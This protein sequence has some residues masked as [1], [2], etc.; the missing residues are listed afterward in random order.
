MNCDVTLTADEFKQVHNALCELR[1]IRETLSGVIREPIT[2]KMGSAIDS[3][4][5]GLQGAYAQDDAAA[6]R[7]SEHYEKVAFTLGFKS[8]WSV[9][10]VKDLYSQ[11]PYAGA[12]EVLYKDHWGDDNVNVAIEG[13]TWADLYRAADLCIRDSGDDHHIFIERFIPSKADPKVLVL[14]TGS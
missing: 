12:T 3:M 2:D 8:I 13:D 7:N 6:G 1:S 11:H 10:E 9:Y 14:S 5:R 4:Y